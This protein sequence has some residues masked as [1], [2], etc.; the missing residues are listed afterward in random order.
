VTTKVP[1]AYRAVPKR[2]V[3]GQSYVYFSRRIGR[4]VFTGAR[5]PDPL[6]NWWDKAGVK[7]DPLGSF[8]RGW[9]R[10]RRATRVLARL[11]APREVRL[12]LLHECGNAAM[13]QRLQPA[14]D[15]RRE[16]RRIG[17]N[18]RTSMNHSPCSSFA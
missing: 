1:C 5:G 2:A 11:S 9:H 15:R 16:R 8:A 4:A 10:R 12:A 17:V 3:I 18:S 6:F 13:R 7:T 14:R